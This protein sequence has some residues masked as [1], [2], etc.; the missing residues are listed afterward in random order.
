[1]VIWNGYDYCIGGLHWR[2]ALE[3]YKPVKMKRID[4]KLIEF[5][6]LRIA[7]EIWGLPGISRQRESL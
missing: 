1:M 7:F 5:S 3:D 6:V 4:K 2:V